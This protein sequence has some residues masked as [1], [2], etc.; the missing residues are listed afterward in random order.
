MRLC[1]AKLNR[2][3]D[4][5]WQEI[6]D[7][8]NLDCHYDH[9]RKVAYGLVE[10]D[11]YLKSGA[12]VATRI[13]SISDLHV[14]FQ[15]PIETFSM[16]A[17]CIDILQLNG[18]LLDHLSISSFP[19][20]WRLSPIEEMIACRQYL[21][22]LIELI[23]PK[24]VVVTYGNHESRMGAYLAKHLDNELQE[25][26]PETALDYIF[27]D[28]F[29][30]YDRRLKTKIY[31]E[32]LQKVFKDENIE[33]EYTGKWYCQIGKTVFCHP[34]AF[35][36]V[37]MKTAEKAMLYFR[38]TGIDMDCLVMAHTHRTGEYTVGNTVMYE[39]GCCCDVTKFD[40]AD[41]KLT[42]PQK[43]GFLYLCQDEQG[44]II[45]DKSKLIVLN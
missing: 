23:K 30:H 43:E 5:D 40:Y 18:D 10:Y 19:R 37:M 14:P 38:N 22:D 29:N 6:V 36:T 12:G 21:I 3:I 42:T 34:K 32:P 28:G 33:I 17:N 45:K 44:Q 41:G 13:L 26:M 9:L 1:K 35:S 25:L 2:E 16:Y 11:N 15:L 24:K 20:S 31:Y 39:Q 27:V 8:L 4:L 7:I